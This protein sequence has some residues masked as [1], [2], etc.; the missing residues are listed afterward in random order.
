M[1]TCAC[2]C[3]LLKN[4]GVQYLSIFAYLISVL[5][6]LQFMGAS[7]P[8][9]NNNDTVSL[10]QSKR[11]SSKEVLVYKYVERYLSSLKQ[12]KHKPGVS[13]LADYSL[14]ST[15]EALVAG[16]NL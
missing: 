12:T 6:L 13:Q 1:C 7:G 2:V 9:N 4:Y 8:N 11:H 3:V 16:S 5:I 14:P 15:P 10:P